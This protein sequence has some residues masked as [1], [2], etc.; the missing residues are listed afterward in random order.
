MKQVRVY[1]VIGMGGK[2]RSTIKGPLIGVHCFE[3]R[4]DAEAS[5]VG[6]ERVVRLDIRVRK[7]ARRRVAR[8]AP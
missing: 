5:C 8:V 7:L 1:G 4:R 6:D 2:I 3:G